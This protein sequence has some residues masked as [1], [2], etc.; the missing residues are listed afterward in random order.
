MR[1]K[2][3]F[4]AVRRLPSGRWQAR[5][6]ARDG[7]RRVAPVTFE[8]KREADRWL[9]ATEA[10]ILR[11]DWLDPGAGKV[12]LKEFAETWVAERDLKPRTR[13]EYARHLRL[14]AVDQL[15]DRSIG[16]LSPSHIRA[17]R[18]ERMSAGVG[19][20][21]VA[22]TYRILHAILST[23]VDDDLIRRNPCRVKGAGQDKADERPTVT[24]DQL[25]AIARAIQPRYRL[26][27][28]LA[29]FAQLRFG[30]LV[31]LR[32]RHLDLEAMEL[33]VRRPR[34]KWRTVRLIDDDPKSEAGK[35]PISLSR[36]AA[37]RTGACI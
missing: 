20:S 10:E 35:R 32:R 31:A 6:T 14:H 34:P 3:R 1:G 22:K 8:H 12:S 15:G 2:R 16:E 18:S 11:G 24:L 13:E 33:R 21:T 29:A 9:V 4:G 17:W 19:R 37:R 36:R 27:V 7:I 23:A 30:E 5:Y 26:L 28:L 25:F